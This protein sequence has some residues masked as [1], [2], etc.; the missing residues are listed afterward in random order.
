MDF[1]SVNGEFLGILADFITQAAHSIFGG[2][3]DFVEQQTRG[4]EELEQIHNLR[5]GDI[6]S[7]VGHKLHRHSP[8]VTELAVKGLRSG[9]GHFH[10]DFDDFFFLVTE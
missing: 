2:S 4:A 5:V 3:A 6:L 9:G 10:L 7:S 8:S 1:H